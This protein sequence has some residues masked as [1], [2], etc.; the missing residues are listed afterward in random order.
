[1]L[2]GS[3]IG[4]LYWLLI[5]GR[6]LYRHASSIN[7]FVQKDTSDNS[8]AKS[9]KI[10]IE[11]DRAKSSQDD[12]SK[13]SAGSSSTPTTPLSPADNA[14]LNEGGRTTHYLPT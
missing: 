1:V 14:R 7:P 9:V 3:L 12:R 10:L 5:H 4:G 11:S 6:S 8:L 13:K 2:L